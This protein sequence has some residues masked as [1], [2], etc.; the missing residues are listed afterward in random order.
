MVSQTG[1]AQTP[2]HCGQ[3]SCNG[4]FALTSHMVQNP[5]CWMAKECNRFEHKGI[6]TCEARLSFV[7]VLLVE[8]ATFFCHPWPVWRILYHVTS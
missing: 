7:F 3:F 5:P 2:L 1:M 8:D 6:P 4:P